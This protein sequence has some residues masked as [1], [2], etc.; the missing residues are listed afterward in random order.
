MGSASRELSVGASKSVLAYTDAAANDPEFDDVRRTGVR[1][2]AKSWGRGGNSD[3][4]F[5]RDGSV[6]GVSSNRKSVCR[7]A[8]RTVMNMSSI[9]KFL[10][11][12]LYRPDGNRIGGE[13]MDG[14]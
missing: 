10:N 7:M 8:G 12:A 5:N 6:K 11:V 14:L 13:V 4:F 9:G 2:Q 3:Y 1:I